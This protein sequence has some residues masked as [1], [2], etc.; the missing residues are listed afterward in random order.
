[1]NA[2]TNK[3]TNKG[4]E[5]IDT[6]KLYVSPKLTYDDNALAPIINN[7]MMAVVMVQLEAW[8]KN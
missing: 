6:P 5:H 1:V 2:V 8:D 7:V 4:D 3:K